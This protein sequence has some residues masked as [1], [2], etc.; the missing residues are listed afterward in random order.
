[1][2]DLDPS[3]VSSLDDGVSSVM[4]HFASVSEK[5][6][7]ELL[8]AGCC[9]G[10]LAEVHGSTDHFKKEVTFSSFSL[11]TTSSPPSLTHSW[12]V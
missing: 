4:S 12:W 7:M 6:P 10:A 3:K 8:A 5:S 1:M 11:R 2:A 9:V